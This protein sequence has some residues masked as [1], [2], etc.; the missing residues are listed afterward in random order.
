MLLKS[1]LYFQ[2][3]RISKMNFASLISIGVRNNQPMIALLAAR[4]EIPF[5]LDC[6]VSKID[7]R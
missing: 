5:V 6:L 2:P 7:R 4:P 3:I 1:V